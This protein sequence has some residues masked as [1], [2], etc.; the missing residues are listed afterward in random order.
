[1]NIVEHEASSY[2]LTNGK[3]KIVTLMCYHTLEEK[4]VLKS[5]IR[6]QF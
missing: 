1:M 3:D 4:I 6:Q 5:P 2:I